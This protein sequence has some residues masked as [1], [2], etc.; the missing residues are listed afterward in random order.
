MKTV[1]LSSGHAFGAD[2][3]ASIG[4][5]H[6]KTPAAYP[7]ARG[8]AVYAFDIVGIGY[9]MTLE[10]AP[11]QCD[12]PWSSFVT[13]YVKGTMGKRA[14]TEE[15]TKAN[16]DHAAMLQRIEADFRGVRFEALEKLLGLTV[17]QDMRDM[18]GAKL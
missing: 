13:D 3:V 2:S 14:F 17:T 7:E 12:A 4:P 16:A 10:S 8:I 5:M 9:R 1:I 18:T 11:F 15:Q 6:R